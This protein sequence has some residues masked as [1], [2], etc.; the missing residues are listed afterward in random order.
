VPSLLRL[1]SA[2]DV[3]IICLGLAAHYTGLHVS[4]ATYGPFSGSG[5]VLP[6][7]G[8]GCTR[9]DAHGPFPFSL[10]RQVSLLLLLLGLAG[11]QTLGV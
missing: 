1:L 5:W 10:S 4:L 8:S 7:F 2:H 3:G 6:L 11:I 9:C